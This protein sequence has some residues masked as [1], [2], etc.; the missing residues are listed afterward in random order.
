MHCSEIGAWFYGNGNIKEIVVGDEVTKIGSHA[1]YNCS[2]LTSFMI[3]NSVKSIGNN[4]F[5][6]C[7]GLTSVTYW[8][9]A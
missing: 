6:G 2:G 4:A 7:S 1:F 9:S 3:P 5:D 8:M